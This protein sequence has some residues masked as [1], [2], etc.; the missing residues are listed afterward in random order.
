MHGLLCGD[1]MAAVQTSGCSCP[2]R[3]SLR[4]RSCGPGVKD[5]IQACLRLA[6][7]EEVQESVIERLTGLL[8]IAGFRRAS[9]TMVSQ[10]RGKDAKITG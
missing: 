4:D 2:S 6:G 7:I 10:V 3:V 8:E 5:L 9:S 1:G